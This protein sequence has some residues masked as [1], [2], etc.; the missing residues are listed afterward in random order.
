MLANILDK[1][2]NPVTAYVSRK[3]KV[4]GEMQDLLKLQKLMS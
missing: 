2:S 3:I 4:K 1:K